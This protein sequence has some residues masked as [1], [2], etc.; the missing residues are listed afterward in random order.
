[1]VVD[2][3]PESL[4]GETVNDSEPNLAVNP[5]NPLEIE[6]SAYT[7]EP[8]KGNIAPIFTST[9]GGET[10]S[11]RSIIPSPQQVFD[12]TLRFSGAANHF[13][14][15]TLLNTPRPFPLLIGRSDDVARRR[16]LDHLAD[17]GGKG[18]DQPYI[19][20]TTVEA[21]DRIFVGEKDYN[22]PTSKTAAIDR[23][24][25]GSPGS[26]AQIA[27]EHRSTGR[28]SCEVRPAIS[29]DGKTV[30]AA[31]N[32]VTHE[33]GDVLTADVVL[34]RD[35]DG[36]NSSAPFTSLTDPEDHTPGLR[37]V[38]NRTFNWNHPM[39]GKDRL[40]GDL[41]VA[42]DPR[43]AHKVYLVWIE[44]VGNVHPTLHLRYSKDAGVTWST[45]V[46]TI[47]DAKNP[48]LAVNENRT[49]GFLYQQ[50]IKPADGKDTWTTNFEQSNDDF[51]TD[52]NVLTLATFPVD[53]FEPG[54][55]GQPFLGDYL[56]L[57]AVGDYFYGIFSS[58]NVPDL[59]R[60]PC[61]V[62][63]Q[64]HVDFKT[65]KLLNDG[66]YVAPSIDPYF[67]KVQN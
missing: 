21:R 57:M 20:A 65:K 34:V 49:V 56:H 26:F 55:R 63:F 16:S 52:P 6:A 9:N 28:D 39:L 41:A 61:K 47:T 51:T 10:W 27:I 8:L 35:D 33:K 60:F 48:G 3:I 43:D 1:M 64:R 31:F 32:H 12:I 54:E 40:G 18:A 7:E 36:G 38:K 17:R 44:Q 25:D 14:V 23:S 11:C 50:V 37:V 29:G 30:Y 58:S 46:R 19:A 42:V 4:S 67:F 66:K 13:Y 22:S 5:A 15:S 24:L 59:S 53:E 45:D 2:I 62:I